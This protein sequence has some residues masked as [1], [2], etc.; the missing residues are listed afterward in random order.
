MNGADLFA[1]GLKAWGAER[2]STL[3]GHGLNEI[4]AACLR[5]G[6]RL[7]DV[8]NEQ[9]AAYMAECAGR[10]TGRV[11]VCAISSG[12]AHA[13]ALTGVL[14]AH[15]DGAPILLLTGCGP[16]ATAGMG[17]FQ[18]F[19][20]VQ[21]AA[22]ICK[23][24]R[25]LSAPERILDDL[26]AA[27]EAALM[28]RPGPVH[29]SFPMDLQMAEV[30]ECLGPPDLD[31]P[32]PVPCTRGCA[33]PL[34][35][36]VDLRRAAELLAASERPLIVAGSGAFYAGA[37]EH[38]AEFAAAFAVPVCVPIW[39]R[40]AV[41][42]PMDEYLGVVGAASGGPDFLR[43]ADLLIVLGAA[44]DY[45][46]GYL[47]AEARVIRV[48]LDPGRRTQLRRVDLEVAA[49]PGLFLAHLED[50]CIEVQLRGFEAWLDEAK[51][52]RDEFC[53]LMWKEPS[54]EQEG[55]LHALDIIRALDA[56]LDPQDVVVVDGGNIGQWFHQPLARRRYPG[57]WLSCGASGVVGYGIGGAMA[58]RL[59][60][61]RRR[62]V[63][64]SGDGSATF[65]L[66]ELECAARQELPFLMIVADDQSWGITEVG[67]RERYGQVM[68]S[69]LGPVEFAEVARGLGA[70]GTRVE[71]ADELEEILRRGL[72]ERV[73]ALVHVPVVGGMPTV[74]DTLN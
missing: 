69:T 52:R 51:R 10:L 35:T 62:V 6:L 34:P 66:T 18:D 38:L 57:H 32:P 64:L 71:R 11:G 23:Y 48:D 26:H 37:E 17:H 21:L 30:D 56:I 4:Y 20:Q 44:A 13:N 27:W 3:C 65:N 47:Q 60:Y 8:R 63:L 53:A 15:F 49:D 7:V 36:L 42:G 29:L 25:T 68:S 16:L 59:L 67:H 50:A 5:A 61:P 43:D 9:T 24:A 12:V 1:Q 31:N 73:P 54:A 28:G 19:D 40:G 41:P 22:P 46:V 33:A 55:G 2:V 58:A 70:V 39:D 14:N 45:R 72:T 74:G